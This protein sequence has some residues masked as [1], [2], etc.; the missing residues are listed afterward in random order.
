MAMKPPKLAITA[1]Y[2]QG[3]RL[4][5]RGHV[6]YQIKI[7]WCFTLSVESDVNY[8]FQ[9]GSGGSAPALA[10]STDIKVSK[11]AV[12]AEPAQPHNYREYATSYIQM[13]S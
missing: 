10:L 2:S 9:Q 4:E 5:G 3:G 8:V 12:L 11:S 6:S 7:C 13:L 1:R